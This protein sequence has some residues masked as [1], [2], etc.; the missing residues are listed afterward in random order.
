ML[1]HSIGLAESSL[2]TYR[3]YSS[4]F[5]ERRKPRGDAEKGHIIGPAGMVSQVMHE[6]PFFV[7]MATALDGADG[8]VPYSVHTQLFP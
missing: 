7:N 3:L 6:C 2:L 5:D 8:R 4:L 1:H